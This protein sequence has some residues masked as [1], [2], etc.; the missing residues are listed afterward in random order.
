MLDSFTSAQGLRTSTGNCGCWLF[1]GDSQN[2]APERGFFQGNSVLKTCTWARVSSS[3]TD[4]ISQQ[5]TAESSLKTRPAL[6]RNASSGPAITT[7]RVSA[8]TWLT[9]PRRRSGPRTTG[10]LSSRK[11][12]GLARAVPILKGARIQR[13]AVIGAGSVIRGFVPPYSVVAGNPARVYRFRADVASIVTHEAR[14]YPPE[15]R[16]CPKSLE[17]Y[18][19]RYPKPYSTC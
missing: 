1:R 6:R 4:A 8:S 16:L 15:A 17:S 3:T 14:L 11:M 2:A 5:F 18:Q 13:G 7:P 9:S 10:M 12:F 19:A